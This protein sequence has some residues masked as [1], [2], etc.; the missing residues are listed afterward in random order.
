MAIQARHVLQFLL[1][2]FSQQT[3][4]WSSDIAFKLEDQYFRFYQIMNRYALSE[5]SRE[6]LEEGGIS[7]VKA[8]KRN[9]IT[10]SP[11]EAALGNEQYGINRQTTAQ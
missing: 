8:I 10:A 11:N 5:D 7:L 4:L 3:K 2:L 9:I 6:L 1:L